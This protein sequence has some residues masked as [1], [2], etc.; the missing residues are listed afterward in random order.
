MCRLCA[1]LLITKGDTMERQVLL[2]T[3]DQRNKLNAIAE[4]EHISVAEVNRRAI[5][6]YLDF[7]GEQLKA[8]ETMAES[9][10]ESNKRTKKALDEAEKELAKTLKQLRSKK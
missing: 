9:L 4:R 7:T 5:E 10:E 3:S 1:I 2:I 8:F 6:Q